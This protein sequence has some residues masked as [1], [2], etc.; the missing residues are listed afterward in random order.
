M[1]GTLDT[2]VSYAQNLPAIEEVITRAGGQV[3]ILEFDGL[4]HLFQRATTGGIAEYGQIETTFEPEA[5]EAM[6]EWLAE[7]TDYD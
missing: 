2:Q 7:V 1:N 5:L 4:N 3:T 6:G